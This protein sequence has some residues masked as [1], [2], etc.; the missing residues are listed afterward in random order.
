MT[1]PYDALIVGAGPGGSSA[2]IALASQGWHVALLERQAFPRDKLCGEFVSPEGIGDLAQLGVLPVLL[3]TRPAP[4]RGVR[5]TLSAGHQIRIALKARGWGL[6]RLTLDSV[7][8]E[9]ARTHGVECLDHCHVRRIEGS[10]NTGFRLETGAAG[11]VPKFLMAKTVIAATGRWSNLTR[12]PRN[13]A[14]DRLGEQRF[15]GLKA[16]FRGDADLEEAVE[17]HF[18]NEG[19]CG[20]NRIEGEQ[21]NLCALISEQYAASYAR[22]WE[23][24]ID[25]AGRQNPHLGD[26]VRAMR[27]SS[28]FLVTSPVAFRTREKVVHD[29]FMVGDAAGFLDPFSGDGISTAVRSALLAAWSLHQYMTGCQSAEGARQSYMRAYEAEFRKR[30]FFA[31][32]IRGALSLPG[33]PS[34]F[35]LVQARIPSLG[36]WVVRQTRGV[37][38]RQASRIGFQVSGKIGSQTP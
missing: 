6:S 36:Q 9:H 29:I 19:Y 22:H 1:T 14:T 30:F 11:Q 15:L 2:A 21:I 26:R 7:L 3:D 18:F 24:L 12:S 16:H 4:V 28:A 33:I 5:V 23:A 8:F 35:A 34:A 31:R 37:V 13:V 10:L 25:A 32:L 38:R 27:R 20:I 17:L